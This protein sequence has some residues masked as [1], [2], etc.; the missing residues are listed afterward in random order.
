MKAWD[1]GKTLNYTRLIFIPANTSTYN[2]DHYHIII[3][4]DQFLSHPSQP[5]LHTKLY[6]TLQASNSNIYD[7]L[8]TCFKAVKHELIHTCTM[9]VVSQLNSPFNKL[10]VDFV[11]YF[12]PQSP[13]SLHDKQNIH[14]N[15][16]K[17]DSQGKESGGWLLKNW[18]SDQKDRCNDCKY[19]HWD[20]ETCL[21]GGREVRNTLPQHKW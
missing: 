16:Q 20:D 4:F 1:L 19:G 13:R 11:K 15:A 7:L 18:K 3:I 12:W 17:Y 2:P 8:N 10:T 5:C 9:I 6:T 14:R 21:H